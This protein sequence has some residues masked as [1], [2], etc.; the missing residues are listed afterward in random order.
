MQL[1]DGGFRVAVAAAVLVLCVTA[2]A[3]VGAVCCRG[4][5]QHRLCQQ[6]RDLRLQ[7]PVPADGQAQAV[8][9]TQ[10]AAPGNGLGH[11]QVYQHRQ[12]LFGL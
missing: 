10:A 8:L 7:L 12:R 4:R 9:Y 6:R 5:A 3:A 2:V 1:I 11:L